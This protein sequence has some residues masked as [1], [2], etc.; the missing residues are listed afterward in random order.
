MATTEIGFQRSNCPF[1][2]EFKMMH[3]ISKDDDGVIVVRCDK[4]K[5]KG[6]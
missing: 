4:F 2:H 3:P 1:E 5:R 6:E